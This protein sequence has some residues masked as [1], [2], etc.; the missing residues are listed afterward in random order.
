MKREKD[1][2]IAS[3]TRDQGWRSKATQYLLNLRPPAEQ[4]AFTAYFQAMIVGLQ[5]C[6]CRSSLVMAL[7]FS[8]FWGA[9]GS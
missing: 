1:Y 6:A 8:H 7:K 2:E 3:G 9:A 5:V 4:H